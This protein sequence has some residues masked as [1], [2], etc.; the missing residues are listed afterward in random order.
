M[1]TQRDKAS[2]YVIATGETHSLRYFAASVFSELGLDLEDHLD[3][4][5]SLRRP[6]EVAR[7]QLDVSRAKTELGW[8]ARSTMRDVASHL[9]ACEL[10]GQLGPVP[11]RSGVLD[12]LRAERSP[13]FD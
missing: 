11:W 13:T 4:D 6:S 7:M 3:V 10:K 8:T 1:I 12:D 2:D 5:P 9:V